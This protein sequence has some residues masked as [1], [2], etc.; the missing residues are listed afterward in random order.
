MSFV[1]TDEANIQGMGRVPARQKGRGRG[2]VLMTEGSATAPRPVSGV[3]GVALDAD[4]PFRGSQTITTIP[5]L[6][7]LTAIISSVIYFGSDVIEVV[8]G[9]F[10][11]FRLVLTLVGEAAIP[12]FI[13]GIYVVQRPRIRRLGLLGAVA[14]ACSDVFFTSTV[15]YA[16][17]AHSLNYE[18]VTTYFGLW[19]TMGGVVMVVGGLALGL[20][21]VQ[22]GQLPRW[23]GISLMLGA[24]LVAAASSLP[25]IARTVAAAFVA[26]AFVGMGISLCSR[27]D[28]PATFWRARATMTFTRWI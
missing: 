6:V 1:G 14:Y 5:L 28:D 20:A 4:S 22:A 11:T 3:A 25:T 26:V 24:I 12:L 13:L 9:D 21:I 17:I 2:P 15:I 10:S 23:T 27:H 19:M 18:A 8:Q 7:G 16:I